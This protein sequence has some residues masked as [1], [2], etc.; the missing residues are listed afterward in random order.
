MIAMAE[1]KEP[2]TAPRGAT[3][4]ELERSY[5]ACRERAIAVAARTC[6]DADEAVDL[7]QEAYLRTRRRLAAFRGDASLDTYLIKATVNLAL[8]AARRRSVRQRLLG[9]L[10][11]P[12][13][14][15]RPVDEVVASKQQAE[16]LWQALDRLSARQ[17]AA[18]I[19]RHVHEYS[20]AEVAELMDISLGTTKT[21]L[22][23]ATERLRRQLAGSKR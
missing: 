3:V 15:A 1:C 7:V 4:Q 2:K 6:G 14:T 12:V 23:R 18:F 13:V 8:K 9:W 16:R 20:V 22:L 11:G 19:L 10:S 21:H 5:V 17:R